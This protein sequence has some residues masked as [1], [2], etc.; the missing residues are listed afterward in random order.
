MNDTMLMSLLIEDGLLYIYWKVDET[1]WR[2]LAER[3]PSGEPELLLQLYAR[4]NGEWDL[5]EEI[6][7]FGRENRWHL[8]IQETLRGKRVRVGLT[9][10]APGETIATSEFIDIPPD[11]AVIGSQMPDPYDAALFRLSGAGRAAA[12]QSGDKISS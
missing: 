12:G 7:A 1:V 9:C 5:A 6:Q 10:R 2:S 8:F 3:A 4:Q 11:L